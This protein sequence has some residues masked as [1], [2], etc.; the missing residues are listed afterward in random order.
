MVKRLMCMAIAWCA[1]LMLMAQPLCRVTAYDEEDGLPHGHVTHLLQDENGFMWFSTWNGLC[2]YDGYE[3]R[4]FKPSV[5]DGCHMLTD[6]IRSISLRPDGRMVLR[7]DEDDYFHFDTH[8]YRFYDLTDEEKRQAEQDIRLYRQSHSLLK[9]EPMRWTDNNGT[10][11]LLT[12]DGNIYYEPQT[13]ATPEKLATLPYHVATFACSDHQGNLWV[14]GGRKVYK[15][16]T[17]LQRTHRLPIEP[18][19][20]VKCLFS[21]RQQRLWVAVKDDQTVRIFSSDGRTLRGYL[22]ADGSIRPTYTRFGAAVYCMYQQPDGTLWMGTKPDGLFRLQ[23]TKTGHFTVTHLTKLPHQAVYGITG[24]PQGR[25]WVATL[26]GGLC[27]T[28]NP[29]AD[30]PQFVI[31]RN[32]QKDSPQRVRYLHIT[33]NGLLLGATTEGLLVSRLEQDADRMVFRCHQREVDRAE[34]LSSSATMDVLEDDSGHILISTESG[35][36]NRISEKELLNDHPVFTHGSTA[37]RQLSNDVVLSLTAMSGQHLLAV[38][39]H[40]FCILDSTGLPRVL[41]TRYFN[42]D[43][44]FSDAHPQQLS[45]GDWLFGLADGAFITSEQQMF[46]PADSPR[47]MLTGISIQ[48]NDSTRV[49][50]AATVDTLMLQPHERSVT[51]RFASIDYAASDRII[52]AFRLRHEDSTD[53]V[54]WNYIG[55]D[56]SATLLDLAP[57]NYLLEIRSTNADGQWTDHVRRLAIIAKPTFWE[58]TTGRLLLL[59]VIATVITAVVYT[60][61]YIRRIKRQQHDTLEKYLALLKASSGQ[62]ADSGQH[63]GQDMAPEPQSSP[64]ASELDPML[65]RLMQFI[66]ENIGNSDMGVGDMA[67]AAAT[68]RSGLQRKLKKVMGITPQD[69]LREARIKHACQL[70]RSTPKNVAEVAYA[71]GFSDPKYFSRCFKQST[72]QSPTEFKNSAP[73]GE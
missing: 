50:D 4:V 12:A 53:S 38:S 54:S 10:S 64:R 62:T 56:R 36:I 72:G 42:D 25:L 28:E 34:S 63:A 49:V 17:D 24:D 1:V 21:D 5:G 52:Y 2:R 6:R 55:H 69:L 18:Q 30:N 19:G 41:D 37:H 32:Y 20:E 58:S 27:Y 40:L 70:L 68:S 16:C 22:S 33:R 66:D 26:G 65:Q 43:Y 59:L 13:D 44:R 57:G 23:E 67:S 8:T 7:V 71:S 48:S 29:Q 31:P 60:I 47:L 51:V 39:N 9:G 11:L 45:N 14:L 3:F 46:R 61:V 73:A 35:G 15:V